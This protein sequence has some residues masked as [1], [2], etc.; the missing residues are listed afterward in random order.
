MQPEQ[1]SKNRTLTGSKGKNPWSEPDDPEPDDFDPEDQ[2]PEENPFPE[3]RG[4]TRLL[5]MIQIIACTAVLAAAVA[6]RLNG[7]AAY[8]NLR[9]WY[10]E[11]LNNSIVADSQV[12][13]IRHVVIDLW[14]T[15]SNSRMGSSQVPSP[16]QGQPGSVPRQSSSLAAENGTGSSPSQ[17]QGNDSFPMPSGASS[18]DNAANNSSNGQN[19]S[20]PPVSP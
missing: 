4:S 8:Q 11:S 3:R 20:S 19:A 5:T 10:F 13:H 18:Q 16:S 14:S 15:I 17:T 1:K 2:E 12:D 9:N 6:L 7:G